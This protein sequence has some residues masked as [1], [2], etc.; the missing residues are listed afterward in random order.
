MKNCGAC[1]HLQ[2]ADRPDLDSYLTPEELTLYH[3]LVGTDGWCIHY[4]Q[5]T[6]Q[7][8]IY[9]QRPSFCRVEAETFGRMFGIAPAEL[10]DFAIDCCEQCISDIYGQPSPE[11]NQYHQ[12]VGLGGG[13]SKD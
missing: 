3:S 12:L 7:C 11:M 6:K 9:S 2:P 8:S 1:C 5:E 13:L 10:N 4:E